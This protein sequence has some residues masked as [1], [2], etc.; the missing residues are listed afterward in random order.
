MKIWVYCLA[1]WVVFVFGLVGASLLLPRWRVRWLDGLRKDFNQ[2]MVSAWGS[3]LFMIAIF[4]LV[5][6]RTLWN[7]V[8]FGVM[9]VALFACCSVVAWRI[10]VWCKSHFHESLA[11]NASTLFVG[12]WCLF[13]TVSL[14]FL[15]GFWPGSWLMILHNILMVIV[16][17]VVFCWSRLLSLPTVHAKNVCAAIL[18]AYALAVLTP[19]VAYAAIL[20][21]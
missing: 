16:G 10:S 12:F 17:V 19:K 3:G 11:D 15:L 20:P 8:L 14:S 21:W 4:V 1:P 18:Y 9:E 5:T 13:C 7:T 6:A 2:E